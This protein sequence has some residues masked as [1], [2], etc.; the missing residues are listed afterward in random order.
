MLTAQGPKLVEVAARTDGILRPEISARTTQLGQISATV[1]A[2]TEPERFLALAESPAPYQLLNHSYNV[3]LINTH[4]GIFH[5]QDFVTELQKLASFSQAVFYIDDGQ[6]IGVTQDVFS[7]PGTIYL[8]H[9]SKDVLR[10]DYRT[11]R[12]L[13]KQGIYL[14]NSG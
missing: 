7:Q 3:C 13:E 1:M 2:I 10:R 6:S 14:K 8:V 4:E 11:I 5:Q 9:S 12:Q